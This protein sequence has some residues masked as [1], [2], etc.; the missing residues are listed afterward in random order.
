[1]TEDDF[2]ADWAAVQR[3]E[4]RRGRGRRLDLKDMLFTLLR[5]EKFSGTRT[6]SGS[7]LWECICLGTEDRP[8]GNRKLVSTNNL[9]KGK[10][11]SCGCLRPQ[12]SRP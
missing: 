7:A 1:M 10:V 8:C 5:V 6:K 11:K 9:M 12:K 2:E 3:R 4:A